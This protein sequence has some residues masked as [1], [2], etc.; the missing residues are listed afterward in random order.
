MG[1]LGRAARETLTAGAPN[2]FTGWLLH[3]MVASIAMSLSSMT[4]VGN[5]LRLRHAR[6]D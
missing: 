4:V 1:H 2:P 3:Q 6:P 5:A